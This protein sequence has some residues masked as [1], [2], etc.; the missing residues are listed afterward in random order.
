MRVSTENQIE[1]YSIDEQIERLEAYCK[2][3]DWFIYK[4]Y[5]D[6]GYSGGNVNRPALERLVADATLKKIDG[7]VVYKLD[8]LSRSQKDTLMLIEDV[9][10]KNDVDF[11]SVSENFDTSTPLGRAM[12]GI[13]SVFAQL[14]KDQITERFTMGRIARSKAGYYHGG[15]TAPTGYDYINGELI[16]NEYQAMQ[17]REVFD[18][19]LSGFSVNSIQEYMHK[20]YG[21]WKSHTLVLNILR[22]PVYIGKVKFNKQIYDG[23]H[24]SIITVDIYNKAQE[25]FK[26]RENG[27][28][29]FQKRPFK[30][31][32]LLT[33]LIYCGKCGS[34]YSGCHGYYKCYSRSKTDKK[35]ITDPNCKNKNLKIEEFDK[36]IA[37]EILKLKHDKKYFE[38]ASSC[39]TIKADIKSI[40]KRLKEIDAQTSKMIDLYQVGNIPLEEISKRIEL[41]QKE[42]NNLQDEKQSM[43]E[44]PKPKDTIDLLNEFEKLINKDSL[45][46]KR[47]V[48]K[49]IINKITINDDNFEI[50]WKF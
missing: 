21:G 50:E 48:I 36:I 25:M 20:K 28:N 41:L 45:P 22:N 19:F 6:A 7:I 10:L 34:R 27:K 49:N 23:I 11:I 32:H 37:N 47:A 40:D 13:L 14:E 31:N 30:A 9:F 12:V 4:F 43:N 33:N 39:E 15:S 5:T 46:Q 16:V 17:V 42:K 44:R 38:K 3:K 24:Q 26:T 35:Y 29:D 2:A 1:N 8:R 18:R